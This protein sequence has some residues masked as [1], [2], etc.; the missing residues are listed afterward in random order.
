MGFSIEEESLNYWINHFNCYPWKSFLE[1]VYVVEQ[2][3]PIWIYLK[4]EQT[5]LVEISP[6]EEL[7]EKGLSFSFKVT[8]LNVVAKKVLDDGVYFKCTIAIPSLSIGYYKVRVFSEKSAGETTLIVVPRQC[9]SPFTNKTWG[10]HC[11]LWSLRGHGKEGD[12]SHLKELAEF[13]KSYGGFISINPLHLN[14]P[15]ECISPYSAISRQFKTPLYISKCPVKEHNE[16]FFDYAFVWKEKI[17]IL[18]KDFEIFYRDYTN[19]Q[20]K[21]FI[22]YKNKLCPAIR[23]DLKYF[24]VFCFLREK[25]GKNWCNWEDRFRKPVRE[26]LDKVYTENEKDVLFY[27]Y[28]QWLVDSELAGLNFLLVDLGF[29]SVKSSF[30]VWINQELYAQGAEYGAPPDDFNP[31]G[32]KWG[33]VPVIPFKLK[34]Q[35]YLP[36]IKILRANMQ[37][38]LLRID[39]ALGLFRAFWIPEDCTPQDGAYVK[40]PWKDLLGI[41][42][43][44]SQLNCTGVIGEDLGTAEEWMREELIKRKICSWKVFY[45]EKTLDGYKKADLYPEDAVCSITTHDLPPFKGFWHGKD[46]ELRKKFSIFDEAQAQNAFNERKK[47]RERIITLLKEE[48]LLRGDSIEEILFAVIKFLAKTQSRYLLLYPEDLFLMEEQANFPGVTTEYPN[49]QRKLPLSVSEIIYSLQSHLAHLF[50]ILKETGRI[51]N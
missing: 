29:G 6:F 26:V 14:D 39:H 36:F 51:L 40:Y 2:G 23:E 8:N 50:Q 16:V 5:V 32:Q 41:I 31:K 13:V 43:L 37:N 45:F 42:A 38:S 20:A 30:D 46:I 22:D 15:E 18:R 4:N 48:G 35:A 11:N 3:C 1:P 12:F 10:L 28:L 27:E 17:K 7:V 47:D 19:G 49:W 44:E 24:S 21:D 25:L 9:F 33:L 34:E